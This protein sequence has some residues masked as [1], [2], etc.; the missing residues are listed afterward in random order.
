[1]QTNELIQISSQNAFQPWIKDIVVSREWITSHDNV[2][3]PITIYKRK[4]SSLP[5]QTVLIL[6]GAYGTSLETHFR[7]DILPL[8]KRG[9]VVVLGHVRGGSELGINWYEDG[10]LYKKENSF[11]DSYHIIKGLINKGIS[12]QARIGV[13]GTSAGGLVVGTLLNRYPGTFEC[14]IHHRTY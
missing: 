1:M 11:L 12:D 6:Y 5:S 14:V 7:M 2:Q 4:G 8:L 10:K 9:F 3:V 13:I